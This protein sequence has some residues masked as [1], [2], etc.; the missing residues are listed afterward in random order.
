MRHIAP[1]NH[2]YQ[3]NYDSLLHE[4][5]LKI[6]NEREV[7]FMEQKAMYTYQESTT[8]VGVLSKCIESSLIGNSLSEEGRTQN[9]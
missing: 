7:D 4:L 9:I 3:V 2:F 1:L 8:T 5:L 6:Y